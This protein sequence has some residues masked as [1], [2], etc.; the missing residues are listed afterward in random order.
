MTV[1]AGLLERVRWPFE[2]IGVEVRFSVRPDHG[3]WY[4]L[5]KLKPD[6]NGRI[7]GQVQLGLNYV[8]LLQ[9]EGAFLQHQVPHEVAHLVAELT[10]R[11]QKAKISPHGAE[12]QEWLARLSADTPSTSKPERD[13][14]V[15]D[16]RGIRLYR[17]GFAMQCACDDGFDVYST[18]NKPDDEG[19][20]SACGTRYERVPIDRLPTEVHEVY[21]YIIRHGQSER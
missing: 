16:G 19:F 1:A 8:F 7:T 2:R 12:W 13:L 20:C 6:E 5:G 10:A 3:S 4:R 18:K 15:Y 9:D 17:G 11:T 14:G 21:E